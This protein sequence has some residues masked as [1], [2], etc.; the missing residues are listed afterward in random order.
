M[1]KVV[2]LLLTAIF[3]FSLFSQEVTFTASAAPSVLRAGEQFNLIY[4]SNEAIS[5]LLLPDMSDFELLG[6]PSQSRSQSVYSENGRITTTSSHQYTY[7]FRALNEGKFTIPAATAKIRNKDIESNSINIE[8]LPPGSAQQGGGGNN[9]NSATV[10]ESDDVFIRLIPDKRDAYVGEPVKIIVKVYTKLNLSNIDYNFQGPDFTGFFI[11]PVS[12]PP[13]RNLESESYNG[14]IFYTAVLREAYII[15][16]H[17]GEIILHPFNVDATVRREVNRR[18]SDP[19]FSDF[20]FPEVENVPVTLTSNT[21]SLQVKGLPPGAPDSFTGA[22]GNFTFESTFSPTIANTNEPLTLRITLSGTGNLKLVNELNMNLPAGLIKYEPVIQ[23]NMDGAVSGEKSFEYLVIPEYP[24][25]YAVPPISFTYFDPNTGKYISVNSDPYTI[26]V[27]RNPWDTIPA[28]MAGIVREDIQL[29]N[30]DIR[31]IKTRHVNL[32][33][34][35]KYFAGSLLYYILIS[36]II[37]ICL[38]AIYYFDRWIEGRADIALLR[39]NRADKYVKKRLQ[40]SNEYL[41]QKQ[42]TELYEELLSALWGYL[43]DKLNIPLSRLSKETADLMLR[44]KQVDS[45][46]STKFFDI[47]SKCEEARYAPSSNNH[48]ANELYQ[49]AFDIISKLHQK[50]K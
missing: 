22:V 30:Q 23:T 15:P 33:P 48:N 29:L 8:V 35:G 25:N 21:V 27:D 45:E 7:F 16:Q 6:G 17:S 37:L 26:K 40:S 12:I 5:E 39:K 1:R 32:K 19:F 18:S 3:S 14:D 4:T 34:K 36:S 41:K 38:L 44:E 20:F 42:Y 31:Y 10:P 46:L 43:S 47:T 50:L 49:S 13:P 28:G 9:D 24:G 2:V 11:E